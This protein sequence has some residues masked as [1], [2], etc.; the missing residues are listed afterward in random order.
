MP[1]T[2]MYH[3][4]KLPRFSMELHWEYGKDKCIISVIKRFQL[5]VKG[6]VNQTMTMLSSFTLMLFETI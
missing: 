6:I 4:T 1:P 3:D 5:K 2:Q